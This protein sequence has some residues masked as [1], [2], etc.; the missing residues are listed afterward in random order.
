MHLQLKRQRYAHIL[1]GGKIAKSKEYC[2]LKYTSFH[3]HFAR[4][5]K[6]LLY[7]NEQNPV[8]KQY[9][10]TIHFRERE[11]HSYKRSYS[12]CNAFCLLRMLSLI[13]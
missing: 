4:S 5:R 10:G 6:I 3:N 2:N 13:K 7:V 12:S 8:M 1:T 9:G 11:R